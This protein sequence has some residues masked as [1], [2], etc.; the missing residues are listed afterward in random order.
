MW[1]N[2][3]YY[4][5][6][7]YDLMAPLVS[8]RPAV[9]VLGMRLWSWVLCCGLIAAGLLV[10]EHRTRRAFVISLVV[11][12]VPLGL[13]VFASTNPSGLTVAGTF[14]A[15]CGTTTLLTAAGRRRAIAGGV[16]AVIGAGAAL[17]SRSDAGIW[18]SVAMG[19]VVLVTNRGSTRGRAAWS[20][21]WSSSS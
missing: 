1:A 18:L 6:G 15:A 11:T 10:A 4:P 17:I 14:A 19:A 9:S 5:G 20:C 3:D 13:F 7:F 12:V 2:F 21:P 8:D 16:V